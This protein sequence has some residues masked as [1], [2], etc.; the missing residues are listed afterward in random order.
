[1]RK[2]ATVWAME[3]LLRGDVGEVWGDEGSPVALPSVLIRSAGGRYETPL[4]VTAATVRASTSWG[5]TMFK[6]ILVALD[7]SPE[8]EAILS[9]VE[10]IASPSTEFVLLHILPVATPAVGAPPTEILV[11]EDRARGYLEAIVRRL[12]RPRTIAS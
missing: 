10:R 4:P 1:M 2:S 9:E 8:G 3:S 5:W 7:S 6:R 11:R 12:A